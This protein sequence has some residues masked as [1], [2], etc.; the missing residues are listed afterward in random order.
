MRCG[1]ERESQSE[2][3]KKG[4]QAFE[5]GLTYLAWL[6]RRWEGCVNLLL[7]RWRLT[8]R[9]R[10]F[11]SFSSLAKRDLVGVTGRTRFSPVLSILASGLFGGLEIALLEG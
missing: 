7:L 2:T 4:R 10:C 1:R 9:L 3:A 6:L 8:R 11:C 5:L